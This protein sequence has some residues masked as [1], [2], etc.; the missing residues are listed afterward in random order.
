MDMETMHI[1]P[2]KQKAAKMSMPETYRGFRIKKECLDTKYSKEVTG[3]N[4]NGHRLIGAGD[5]VDE[6]FDNLIAR[7]DKTLDGD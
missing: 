6:A 2:T 4:V 5:T 7:I 3:Y 1:K